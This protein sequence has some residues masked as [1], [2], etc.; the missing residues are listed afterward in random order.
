M[1][2][3][4]WSDEQLKSLLG[5][6]PSIKDERD[7]KVIYQRIEAGKTKYRP[8]RPW[9]M[10]AV[11]TVFALLLC[12]V[13]GESFFR[14]NN[15]NY[16]L[17]DSSKMEK[18]EYI[19]ISEDRDNLENSSS[20][21]MKGQ[22]DEIQKQQ[23]SNPLITEAVYQEDVG[24]KELLTYPIPDKNAQVAVPV[25]I[26]VDNPE[27]L[28]KFDLYKKYMDVINEDTWG[29]ENYYPFNGKVEYDTENKT[30]IIDFSDDLTSLGSFG[31]DNFLNSIVYQQL[32]SIGAK[33]MEFKQNG[34]NG[35][36]VGNRELN[37]MDYHP[38]ENR[39]YFLLSDSKDNETALYVP[40]EAPYHD[41]ETAISNMSKDIP[42]YGLS[43]S[44]PENISF[45]KII[46]NTD[47]N[48]LVL[49]FSNDSSLAE[50]KHTV[51][52]IETI[53]LTAKDFEFKTVKF[54]N[55]KLEQI[56]KFTMDEDINVPVAANKREIAE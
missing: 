49:H 14:P 8:R 33:K 35:V 23:T 13:I 7:P 1:K 22:A 37:V 5:Q 44:I 36:V 15:S 51:R 12:I 48:E 40:W 19:A 11:A 45:D 46:K 39:G 34:Q 24:N 30:V 29:L 43:A 27:N 55:A 6:F 47:E 50:D 20:Y 42:E 38:L 16:S 9:L 21:Q 18:S 52:A 2:K 53:L 28:S 32:E 10:P 31:S 4:N 26:L 41:I 25:S 54:E 3:N 56:G 17:S